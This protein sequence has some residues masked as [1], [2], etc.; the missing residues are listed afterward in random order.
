[1]ELSQKVAITG[2]SGNFLCGRSS[3]MDFYQ[4]GEM[5]ISGGFTE[6]CILG[7]L[8]TSQ[9]LVNSYLIMV[10]ICITSAKMWL[11]GV[12]FQC[13]QLKVRFTCPP[14][15]S[16]W[17]SFTIRFC[18]GSLISI[19]YL[20]LFLDMMVMIFLELEIGFT[21]FIIK[22]L[23][24]TMEAQMDLLTGFLEPLI[25]EQMNGT[26]SWRT[27]RRDRNWLQEEHQNVNMTDYWVLTSILI[28]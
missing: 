14:L 23:T 13:I 5:V 19:W 26:R 25:S 12:E 24:W 17:S 1:M 27:M 10:I 18:S 9:I 7:I 28:F 8:S 16:H 20:P 22:D 11:L 21:I 15:S 2:I 6:Q 3:G 4:V